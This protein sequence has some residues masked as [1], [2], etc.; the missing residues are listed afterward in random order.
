M[1]Q[2]C[3]GGTGSDFQV[4]GRREGLDG[5]T[6][7]SGVGMPEGLEPELEPKPSSLF[8]PGSISW[9]Q[10]YLWDH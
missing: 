5:V 10:R 2:A 8:S 6:A 4:R 7:W 3:L 1:A 9:L